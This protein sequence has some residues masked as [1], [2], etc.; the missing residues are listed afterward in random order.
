MEADLHTIFESD[1]YRIIDFKCRC[2]DCVTSKPEY[3]NSFCISFVRKGNFLFNVF[4]HSLDSYTG[5]VLVTKPG[6]EHT[7]THTHTIPDECTIFD[8]TKTFYSELKEQY[9]NLSFFFNNDLHSTLIKT[10][11]QTEFLHFYIMRLVLTR[12]HS[13]LEVD[14][15]VLEMA[16]KN[17]SAISDYTPDHKIDAR[18]KINHLLTIERAKE[19]ITN[20]FT[21]DIS[22]AEI[23]AYSYVSPFHFS[24]IFKIFTSCSPHRFLLSVRLQHA[25]MLLRNTALPV[26][27]IGFSSGFNSIEYFTAAFRHQYKCPPSKFRSTK[28]MMV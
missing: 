2:K 1:F 20:H 6:Y 8:F 4:R 24:R 13:K 12:T 28:E 21:E 26:A 11:A 19:Y 18:L 27:D 16:E 22:L 14:N 3:A 9:R 17:L 10:S 7:V 23:S 25:A 5:C 15:L